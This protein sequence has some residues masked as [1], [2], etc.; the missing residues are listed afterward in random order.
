MILELHFDKYMLMNM[1]PKIWQQDNDLKVILFHA[2][3]KYYQ[4]QPDHIKLTEK[5]LSTQ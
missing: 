3:E 4:Q 1:Q 2:W 5:Y